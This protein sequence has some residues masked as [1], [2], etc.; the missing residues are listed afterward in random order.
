[1]PA[2]LMLLYPTVDYD[3]SR[4]SVRKYWLTPGFCGYTYPKI[5]E[6]YLKDGDHGMPEYATPFQAEDVAGFPPVYMEVMECDPLHDEGCA[7]A[8]KLKAAGVSV[9]F[10]DVSKG[11][12]G[13][14]MWSD[15]PFAKEGVNRRLQ[16]WKELVRKTEG[17]VAL[18]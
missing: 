3:T 18:S 1:M 17:T 2:H 5:Y 13:Y 4:E 15:R 7:Y 9:D 8:E 16:V 14:D 6:Y 12:H 10:H 11:F